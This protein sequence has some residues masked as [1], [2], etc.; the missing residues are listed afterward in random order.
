MTTGRVAMRAFVLVFVVMALVLLGAV[1]TGGVGAAVGTPSG[2]VVATGSHAAG[3]TVIAEQRP[4]TA[5]PAPA[6]ATDAAAA[7]RPPAASPVKSSV[8]AAQGGGLVTSGASFVAPRRGGSGASKGTCDAVADEE[9]L[10]MAA[11][12]PRDGVAVADRLA[13]PA[14]RLAATVG[15]NPPQPEVRGAVPLYRVESGEPADMAACPPF[16]SPLVLQHGSAFVQLS[17]GATTEPNLYRLGPLMHAAR[18]YPSATRTF[19]KGVDA[20]AVAQ[21][22]AD[23]FATADGAKPSDPKAAA[24]APFAHPYFAFHEDVRHVIIDIGTNIDPDSVTDFWQNK[25][26][27]M[28]WIEAIK[29]IH[30]HA[31]HL[32][33]TRET[34]MLTRQRVMGLPLAVGPTFNYTEIHLSATPGCTSMLPMNDHALKDPTVMKDSFQGGDATFPNWKT[35]KIGFERC[36]KKKDGVPPEIV[37]VVPGEPLS[38][39]IPPWIS[40]PLLAVDAQGFDLQVMSSFG[41]TELTRADHLQLECQDL[42]EGHP[43]FLTHGAFSCA[44]VRHCVESQLPHRMVDPSTMELSDACAINNPSHERNCLFRRMERPRLADPLPYL[45]RR[46]RYKLKYAKRKTLECPPIDDLVR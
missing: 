16:C 31:A 11:A 39:L 13:Q 20:A 35:A 30:T 9:G 14:P 28:L 34:Q 29:T 33:K 21:S 25:S 45:L 19:N 43:M 17:R 12:E 4:R 42:P 41:K 46:T 36:I 38:R 22:R 15:A 1:S 7:P 27:G 37:P 24:A 10:Y 2:G 26:V 6:A 8:D 23:M 32:P 44:D 18:P 3:A 40:V 5:P